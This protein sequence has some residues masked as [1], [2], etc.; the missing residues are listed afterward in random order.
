MKK[1][2]L[3]K[4]QRLFESQRNQV[5]AQRSLASA[6]LSVN[7]DDRY[8][9]VDQAT[10][11]MEQLMRM[12]L[13]SRQAVHLRKLE[14]ALRRIEQGTYGECVDCGDDIEIR[15][16]EA[17]PTTTLCVYCKEEQERREFHQVPLHERLVASGNPSHY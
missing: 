3:R 14:E 16:L 13:Q 8:D 1:D 2:A 9:E 10:T 7:P 15:R 5:L 11:D 12:R 17:R 4:F 6:E